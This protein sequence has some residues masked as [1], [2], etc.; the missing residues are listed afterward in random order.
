VSV[1]L[2][3]LLGLL[4]LCAELFLREAFALTRWSPDLAQ[5]VVLWLAVRGWSVG[6]FVSAGLVGLL[7][8]GFVGSPVGVH[9]LQALLLVLLA[10]LLADRVRFRTLPGRLVLGG[11]GSVVGLLLLVLVC[12]IFLGDTAIGGRVLDLLLPR[13]LV[14]MIC[15]PLAFPLLDR[16]DALVSGRREADL[17]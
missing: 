3:V 15:V 12:R 11:V 6:G 17:A 8:D 14:L 7:A 16:L 9:M 13:S 2:P 5:V 10:G 1:V 4:A